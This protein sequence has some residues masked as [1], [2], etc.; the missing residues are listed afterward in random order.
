ML[1]C[2]SDIQ[3]SS[4]L[5]DIRG[6]QGIL[7]E[8]ESEPSVLGNMSPDEFVL[9]P[10]QSPRQEMRLSRSPEDDMVYNVGSIPINTTS[11]DSNASY[12]DFM[13]S[14]PSEQS[15]SLWS[16]CD[17]Q[18]GAPGQTLTPM[19]LRWGFPT[20]SHLPISPCSAPAS[21]TT[22]RKSSMTRRSRTSSKSSDE[23]S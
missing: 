5:R 19:R 1:P 8:D 12:E 7:P 3:R 6:L 16:G 20:L 9:L 17:D 14:L 22:R 13:G 15:S 4:T 18:C 23:A 11:F 2:F 21:D 10:G